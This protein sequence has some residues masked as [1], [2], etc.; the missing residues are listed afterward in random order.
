M[1]EE[2]SDEF[3]SPPPRRPPPRAA[4]SGWR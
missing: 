3:A 2:R 1:S 4:P